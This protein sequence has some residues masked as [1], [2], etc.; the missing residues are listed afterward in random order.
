MP[1]GSNWKRTGIYARNKKDMGF[2]L[3]VP[4]SLPGNDYSSFRIQFF[5]NNV[6]DIFKLPSASAHNGNVD[7]VYIFKSICTVIVD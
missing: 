6:E 7:I 5:I 3:L 4:C 2:C 1:S